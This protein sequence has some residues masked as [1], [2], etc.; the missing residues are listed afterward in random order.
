[1]SKAIILGAGF[2]G[3]A[4]AFTLRKLLP[5]KDEVIIVDQNS[6]FMVGFRKTWAL[7]G[8]SPLSEGQ[9]SLAELEKHGI[10][11][12]QG[13]INSI[14]PE[15]RSVSVDGRKIEA[16]A[17]V[18]ALGARLAGEEIPGFQEHAYNVYDANDIP[19]AA[20][21]LQDFKG[22]KIVVGIFGAPYKCPW[23]YRPGAQTGRR[24]N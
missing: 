16:D 18:V 1:M 4:T 20:K 24:Q 6:Y 19:R 14:D 21:A 8:H 22:G 5:A 15:N 9:G 3:L 7:L 11:F 13:T 12:V 23:E 2:G 10:Q 17:M